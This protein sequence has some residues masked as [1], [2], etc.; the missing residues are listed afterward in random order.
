[1]QPSR[2]YRS[3][4]KRNLGIMKKGS[5]LLLTL[6]IFFFTSCEKDHDF[7]GNVVTEERL[8]EDD[9]SEVLTRG[10]F[11]VIIVSDEEFDLKIECGENKLPFID[12]YVQGD[13]LYIIERNNHVANDKDNRIYLN[14]QYFSNIEI[15]GSGDF[16][17]ELS[18]TENLD[19]KIDGSGDI[20]VFVEVESITHLEIDGS[21]DIKLTGESE[22]ID[23]TVDG[24]GDTDCRF[25]DVEEA[26]LFVDG[27]GDAIINA[28]DLL[29]VQIY[30]SGDVRY[31][32]NPV[33]EITDNGSG[34][35]SPY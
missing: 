26:H 25:F 33:L 7:S 31:L 10:S 22:L 13:R 28:S 2:F 17:G 12:T 4:R 16:E 1:M 8:I 23:L 29:Q 20:D 3:L 27:S 24:S 30:G 21:G 15:E 11:D 35:V 14:H 19:I 6:G 18:P 32:G 9:Y 5:I 34:D